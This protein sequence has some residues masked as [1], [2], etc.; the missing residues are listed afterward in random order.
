MDTNKDIGDWGEEQAITHL[1]SLGYTIQE[2]NWKWNNT[3]LDI[4]AKQN[5]ILVF[6]EVKT[7]KSARYGYPEEF[8]DNAQQEQIKR[9]AEEYIY[10]VNHDWEIR[11][12]IISI[13]YNRKGI[14]DIFHIKDA[15]FDEW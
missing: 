2:R 13:L 5:D 14:F 1:Q 8:V 15:F 4:I 12:D 7:R 6:V 9:A 10:R 11:F 3:E